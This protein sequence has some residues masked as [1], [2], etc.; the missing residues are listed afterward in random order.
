M[1]APLPMVHARPLSAGPLTPAGIGWRRPKFGDQPQNFG[2]QC[3]YGNF[4]HLEGDIAAMGHHLCADLDQLLLQAGQHRL[5]RRQSAQEIA[6]IVGERGK[7]ET[8]ELA[9]AANDR[10]DS[11]VQR[12]LFKVINDTDQAVTVTVSGQSL[13]A[14][15]VAAGEAALLSCDGSNVQF[16][17]GGGDSEEVTQPYD[18][19]FAY[20]GGPPDA[21]EVLAKVIMPRA[22][23][24]P[25]NLAGS[26]GHIDTNPT[27]PFDIDVTDD[28][29]SIG[30][31]S[32]A[33]TGAFTFTTDGGTS[34]AIGAGSVIRFMAPTTPDATAAS[35]AATLVG[36]LD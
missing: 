25:A 12:G 10:H 28:G 24:L 19:G 6:E 4:A 22:M 8:D 15:T 33:D 5:V 20:P 30:T 31:I 14:P 11:R 35:F 7:L 36:T 29:V 34:K 17:G 18:F 2:E 23:I 27:A 3:P 16:A 13:T 21:D 32:I 1:G 26:A 9:L